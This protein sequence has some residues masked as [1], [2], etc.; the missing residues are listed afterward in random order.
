MTKAV[1]HIVLYQM[2]DFR[3]Q[4]FGSSCHWSAHK[5]MYSAQFDDSESSA[6][7][8]TAYMTAACMT[9]Y[10]TWEHL[11]LI[12][13]LVSLICSVQSFAVDCD[14]SC[15]ACTAVRHSCIVLIGT[16]CLLLT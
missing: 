11:H 13:L 7:Y 9:A 1:R 4:T 8:M 12:R 2:I 15:A 14:I 5:S 6:A 3:D 10:M 16:D